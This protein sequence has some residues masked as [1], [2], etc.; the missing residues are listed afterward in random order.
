MYFMCMAWFYIKRFWIGI[1][2]SLYEWHNQETQEK[3][4]DDTSYLTYGSTYESGHKFSEQALEQASLLF[5]CQTWTLLFVFP[6]RVLQSTRFLL[7]WLLRALLLALPEQVLQ[8][9]RFL[10][11]MRLLLASPEER[12]QT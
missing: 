4:S 5:G 6:G 3:L 11:R 8:S 1:A 7:R 9:T 2:H 10:L 12:L